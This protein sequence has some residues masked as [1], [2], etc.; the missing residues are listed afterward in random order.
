MPDAY[1]VLSY[2]I[3]TLS[4]LHLSKGNLKNEFKCLMK[5]LLFYFPKLISTLLQLLKNKMDFFYEKTYKFTHYVVVSWIDDMPCS[6]FESTSIIERLWR[7]LAAIFPVLVS[8]HSGNKLWLL[9][10]ESVPHQHA[11][12]ENKVGLAKY[13]H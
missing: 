4:T 7:L 6:S 9:S 11:Q 12:S 13:Q 2:L 8:S 1:L 10:V 3:A 5:Y